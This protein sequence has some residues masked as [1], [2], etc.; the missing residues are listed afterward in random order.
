MKDEIKFDPKNFRIHNDRNKKVIRKSLEDCGAGRSVLMD[1]DNY[2]IA[3]NGVYEQAQELGIPV[4]I[5][6]TDGKEL[7]VVKRKDLALGDN[8]RKLLALADNHASDT[9]EFDMELV[10]ENFSADVL[11]DWEFSVDDIDVS[12]E[13]PS[14]SFVSKRLA[15]SF[16]I[17]PFSI[18]DTRQG[19]WQERKREWLSIGI[20]SEIGREGELTYARSSQSPQI[21]ELRNRLREKMGYDPSW[22]EI[23]EYCQKNNIPMM[24]G[25]SI[26][27]PV[28]CELSYR[29][30][31]IPGGDIIDPFAGGSVR[32]IVA[33]KLGMG[34]KGVD[35]RSEQIKANYENV[36]KIHPPMTEK[37]CP[38]WICGD[39]ID[40]DMHCSGV[41]A[42]MIFSCPPYADLEVYSDDPRD[43]SNMEYESFLNAYKIIIRK[44]CSLLK[45]NRFAVFVVGEV[46]AKSGEYY[47]FVGDTVKAFKEAGL[48][49]YNEMIIVNQ[50]GSLAMRAGKQFNHSRKIG[51]CHQNVLVFYKGD[52]K[53]IPSIYP[54]IDLGNV[55]E[56][57]EENI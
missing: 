47:D 25:T 56:D 48:H 53:K 49:Y 31:N 44:S 23:T 37:E 19:R 9:S 52:L 2:L 11:E 36:A 26:F 15:D 33:A 24:G 42:D 35:L 14:G 29:W 30:F 17:P 16:I 5:I 1:K 54:E 22:D 57:Y 55:E 21:Y 45:E 6:E 50:I 51:K 32:G 34:Y 10:I 40:I 13:L 41:E 3:G 4:R 8:R 46:R 7:V 38:T 12:D 28:L 39:S 27:D 43:L 20:N 18:L